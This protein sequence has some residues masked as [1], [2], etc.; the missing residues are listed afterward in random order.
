M[1]DKATIEMDTEALE[2]GPS[3]CES[4]GLSYSDDTSGTSTFTPN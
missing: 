2:C 4:I 1:I 3:R